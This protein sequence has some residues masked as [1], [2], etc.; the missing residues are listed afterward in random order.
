[1]L[2]FISCK[3][4][5]ALD[6]K[7]R[8]CYQNKI[9][10]HSSLV[11]G[12]QLWTRSDTRRVG[13]E[14]VKIPQKKSGRGEGTSLTDRK[15]GALEGETFSKHLTR[16]TDQQ[17]LLLLWPQTGPAGPQEGK[18]HAMKQWPSLPQGVIPHD[19]TRRLHSLPETLAFDLLISKMCYSFGHR[20]ALLDH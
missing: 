13:E 11:K 14:G 17:N 3:K 12:W 16:F 2:H 5:C 9:F 4:L 6:S 15:F 18:S 10:W 20:Q 1:M 8:D 19:P 7:S